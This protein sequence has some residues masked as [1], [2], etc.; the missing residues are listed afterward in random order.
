MENNLLVEGLKLLFYLFIFVAIAF[1]AKYTTEFIAK[2]NRD[3]MLAKEVKLIER[4]PLSKEREIVL[5]EYAHNRYLIS[6][7]TH[8]TT[9][10]DKYRVEEENHE[11]KI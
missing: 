3:L 6:S 5:V 9:L 2:R 11:T 4:V 8:N 7:S 1:M 10:I